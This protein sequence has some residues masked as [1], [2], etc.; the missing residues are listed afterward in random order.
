[1]RRKR[2]IGFGL[3]AA[4]I[5]LAS[6]TGCTHNH[7]Y[8]TTPGA[9][10]DPCAPGGQILSSARPVN[11]SPMVGSVCDEPPQGSIAL[12]STPMVSNAGG[13]IAPAAPIYSRPLV[14]PLRRGGLAWRGA[15]TESLA[16]TRIEGQ[17]DD[18]SQ[19]K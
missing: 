4:A 3:T 15:N 1:M 7:Y 2:A 9:V 6:G 11:S 16:T 5:V 12:R 8:Y 18:D 10:G 19:Y 13:P 17:Y 14:R